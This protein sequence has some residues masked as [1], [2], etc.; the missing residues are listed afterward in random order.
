MTA[1]NPN[2][3]A[4]PTTDQDTKAGTPAATQAATNIGTSGAV[5]TGSTPASGTAG[6]A[7]A[8]TINPTVE[9][10]YWKDNYSKRPYADAKMTQEQYA[11]AYQYGWDSYKAHGSDG[12]TFDNV[13]S[14]LRRGWDKAKGSSRL[15]WDQAKLAT[16]DAWLRVELA[17]RDT[18]T[19]KT[20]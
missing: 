9:A 15:A 6:N 7:H 8:N 14:D 5:A 20:K 3:S 12:K 11:P 17:A 10:Q 2:T 4:T 13:E 18:T 1:G 19:T 16:R